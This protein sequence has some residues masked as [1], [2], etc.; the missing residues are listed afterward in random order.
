[1][2]AVQWFS[3]ISNFWQWA[4]VCC[5]AGKFWRNILGNSHCLRI[6]FL[7]ISFHCF[8]PFKNCKVIFFF[9]F[10]YQSFISIS[11]KVF[12]IQFNNPYIKVTKKIK[13]VWLWCSTLSKTSKANPVK[14]WLNVGHP[15]IHSSFLQQKQVREYGDGKKVSIFH[16]KGKSVVLFPTGKSRIEFSFFLW[17]LMKTTGKTFMSQSD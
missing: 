5:D 3:F 6:Y 12:N 13:I 2:Y 1:M 9:F 17:T 14:A 4:V 15:L 8:S 7:I 10:D 11:Q 16:F